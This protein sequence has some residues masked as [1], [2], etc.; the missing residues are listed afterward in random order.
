MPQRSPG[1][2]RYSVYV[3]ELDARVWNHARFREANPDHDITKPCVYV[4]M[5]GLPIE[6][7]FANHRR[8]HKSNPFVARYGVR[9][10]PSLYRRLNPMRYELA[11]L[12]EVMLAQRLRARGYAVWQ[13]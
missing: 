11:R 4:G 1:K 8:G 7:R 2:A 6:R 13:A 3:I 9:L 12:T 5:T 10:L